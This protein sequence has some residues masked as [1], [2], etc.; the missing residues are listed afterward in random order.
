MMMNRNRDSTLTFDIKN[1]NRIV[2]ITKKGKDSVL[3]KNELHEYSPD[4][5]METTVV[6]IVYTKQIRRAKLN[7]LW[8]L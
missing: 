5:S 8:S 7:A 6:N 1:I 2:Y 3:L 4:E